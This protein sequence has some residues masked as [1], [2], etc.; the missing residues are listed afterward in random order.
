VAGLEEIAR[1]PQMLIDRFARDQQVH[2]LGRTLEDPV[3][4]HVAQGLLGRHRLFAARLERRRGLVT[5]AAANLDQLVEHLPPHLRAVQLGEGRLDS[6]VARLVVGQAA[7]DV[8]HRL[9]A[10]C[11]RRDERDL[12]RDRVV[13]ADWPSPLDPLGRPLPRHLRRPLRLPDA[14]R[15]ER[16]APRVE[17]GQRDLQPL[18][19]PPDPVLLGHEHVIEPCH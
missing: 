2:D 15:R 3:D 18:S 6:D 13:L 17:R 14:D 8:K 7:G 19:L 5:P 11:A 9:E 12:L 10:E 16:Q 4:P 1:D